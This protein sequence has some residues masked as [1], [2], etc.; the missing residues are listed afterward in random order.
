MGT[1]RKIAL[2]T[3]LTLACP[4]S[5]PVLAFVGLSLSRSVP[6]SVLV[7]GLTA[8]ALGGTRLVMLLRRHRS[9]RGKLEP[10]CSSR[11]Q[12]ASLL[13]SRSAER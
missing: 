9:A 3:I 11:L 13:E 12:R 10:C 7:T 4:C 5:W 6:T 1:V 8:V 2:F